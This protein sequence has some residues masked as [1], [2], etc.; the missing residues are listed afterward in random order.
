MPPF[1][2]L[3]RE[4]HTQPVIIP[5]ATDAA[6]AIQQVADGGGTYVDDGLEYSH[7]QD[8]T[9]WTAEEVTIP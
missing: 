6:D 9:T 5:N 1:R 4:V 7:T 2:V 8:P 3:V